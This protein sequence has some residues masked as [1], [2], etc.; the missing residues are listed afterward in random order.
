MGKSTLIQQLRFGL[1]YVHQWDLRDSRGLIRRFSGL[2]ARACAGSQRARNSPRLVVPSAPGLHR[3][4][5][6][7]SLYA[8][9]L[10]SNA[11]TPSSTCSN[12]SSVIR[13]SK[14]PRERYLRRKGQTIVRLQTL[15][16]GVCGC[17]EESPELP[18]LI[19]TPDASHRLC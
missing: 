2:T 7:R 4:K 13:V 3:R 16:L 10:G 11:P 9:S 17:C 12:S 14:S 18:I 8:P 19:Q 6:S 1:G 15:E 5:M